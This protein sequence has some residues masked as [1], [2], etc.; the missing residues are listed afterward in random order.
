M[1]YDVRREAVSTYAAR[2]TRLRIR[3]RL[4]TAA[5]TA[6]MKVLSQL[7]RWTPWRLTFRSSPAVF[8]QPKSSSTRLRFC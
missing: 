8:N 4:Y 3:T 1:G 5:M 7:T 2:S 6:A